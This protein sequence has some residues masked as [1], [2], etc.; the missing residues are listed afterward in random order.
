MGEEIWK[1]VDDVSCLLGLMMFPGDVLY[2]SAL[3]NHVVILNKWE[4]AEEL[5]ENRSVKYS[6][7]PWIPMIEKYG[8]PSTRC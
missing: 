3:G 2:G 5:L 1:Y 4:D 6:D 8:V 7:R